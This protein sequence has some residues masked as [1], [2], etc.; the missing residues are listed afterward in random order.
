M[1]TD[2]VD[3]SSRKW[4]VW[5]FVLIQIGVML[6][7]ISNESLWIDEFWTAGFALKNNLK[8]LIEQWSNPQVALTPLHYLY[9]YFWGIFFHS[10]EMILRLANLP[11]FVLGQLSLFLALRAYPQRFAFLLLVLCALHPMVW[12][13]ANEARPYMMMY[14]G[15]EMI[16]AYLLH[17]HMIQSREDGISPLFSAIFVMGCI[18]LLGASMLGGFWVFAAL[19]Y[20]VYYHYNYLN[21]RYLKQGVTFL[22]LGTLLAA[23]AVLSCMYIWSILRGGSASIL[24]STT[25]ATVLFDMYELLGLSGIGP[26]RIELRETGMAALSPYWFGLLLAVAAV[27][28]TLLSGLRRA[29]KLLGS[30]KVVFATMVCLL[31]VVIVVFS[32]FAMHWRVLGRHLIAELPVINLL[33]A[34]GL[35]SLFA[36]PDEHGWSFRRGIAFVFLLLIIYSSFSMRFAGRHSKDDYRG[37]VAVAM[38]DIAQ[39]KLVWWAADIFGAGY[40]GLVEVKWDAIFSP[41]ANPAI[42]KSG[43]CAANGSGFQMVANVSTECL[44]SLSPPNVV[45]LSKLDTF[46]RKGEITSYLNTHGF[47]KIQTLPAFTIWRPMAAPSVPNSSVL[48]EA[49]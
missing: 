39:G 10:G 48:Q 46:D 33:L 27:S 12:Q 5:I 42:L 45:I 29:V 18:L 26:G 22:L 14:A 31:P 41:A 3:W 13:Y 43:A 11:L 30:T 9:F 21:W 38:R 17:I 4:V 25:V 34:L 19:A 2:G 44:E 20:V 8:D 47:V 28:V 36:K 40:Y 15:A 23:L 1:Q 16:L 32:G 7:A 6:I 24:S 35:F 49:H 37:A